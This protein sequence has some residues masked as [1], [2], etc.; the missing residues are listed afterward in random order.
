[1]LIFCTVALLRMIAFTETCLFEP[2]YPL[3]SGSNS[4]W[5]AILPNPIR[6]IQIHPFDE[7]LCEFIGLREL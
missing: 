3:E 6:S 7:S 1:M 5:A 2:R 4:S